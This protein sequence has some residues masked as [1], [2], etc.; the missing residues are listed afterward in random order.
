MIQLAFGDCMRLMRGME[1]NSV[2]CVVT[3]IPFGVLNSVGRCGLNKVEKNGFNKGKADE[4]TFSTHDFCEE[5]MRVCRG[6]IYVFCATEQVSEIRKI[7]SGG[8]TTRLCV[9]EKTN[10]S[11]INGQN[12]WLSGVECCIYGKFKGATFNEHCR[13]TVFR[14]PI[15]RGKFHPTQKPVELL[16]EFILAST[17]EGDTVLDPCMGSGSTGIACVQT[18]RNFIGIE[19]DEE[20]YNTAV[21][22]INEEKEKWTKSKT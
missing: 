21:K 4:V 18:G 6:S 17:N 15:V 22:R 8:M 9:W 7:F 16:K 12:V 3:D 10:P 20:F 13:N 2:D 5:V 1:D 14:Y 19:L 11:P